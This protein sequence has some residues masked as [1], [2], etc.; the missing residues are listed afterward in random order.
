MM[1]FLTS[2]KISLISISMPF[3]LLIAFRCTDEGNSEYFPDGNRKVEYEG[4]SLHFVGV[5]TCVSCHAT[6]TEEWLNSHHDLAMKP[7]KDEYV[8]GDF[9]NTTFEHKGDTY[10]FFREDS[11]YKVEAPGEDGKPGIYNISYTFGRSEER[12]VG[13]E[14]IDGWREHD[15]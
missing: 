13:T 5:E 11:I 6:E 3:V 9:E 4:D 15:R 14:C 2:K 10:R 8:L 1:N 7:A 12:R